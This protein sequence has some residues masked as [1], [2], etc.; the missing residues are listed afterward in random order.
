L[1]IAVDDLYFPGTLS[2]DEDHLSALLSG[3]AR[4]RQ[5][6]SREQGR[7][8]R[9]TPPAHSSFRA[10]P[11]RLVRRLLLLALEMRN[12]GST[13]HDEVKPTKI[14]PHHAPGR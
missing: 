12:T 14:T 10:R 13:V 7:R 8:M 3:T 11:P 6:E 4:Q 1:T 2:V 5:R 9:G